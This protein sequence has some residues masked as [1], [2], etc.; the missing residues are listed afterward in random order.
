[1]LE[2][3]YKNACDVS[4][5]I[6]EHVPTHR[7]LAE[8]C[9]SVVEVG[10]RSMVSTWGLLRG[11][12]SGC[13]YTGID[14]CMPPEE[15][16]TKARFVC[17]EAGIQFNFICRD[18]ML[19][20][21]TEVG[22]CD[23]LF[24]DS[25]HTYCHLR[26]E[27]EKFSGLAKKYIT[28]HDTSAPWDTQ[29][30]MDYSG[31]YSEYPAHYDRTKRGTWAAIEHFLENNSEWKIRER[32][33]NN[34]GFTIL[35]RVKT[36]PIRGISFTIPFEKIVKEAPR[37][38]VRMESLMIPGKQ[39]TYI[40]EIEE[41]YYRQYQESHFAITMKKRGW[42]CLR[43]LEIMANGC[44]PVF[45]GF[46]E[47]PELTLS[48]YP[49]Q[50]QR[51]INEFYNIYRYSDIDEPEF[52]SLYYE[53]LERV[54]DYVRR[55]MTTI[56]AARR[57]LNE[58]GHANA[59][60]I[61]FLGRERGAD[62]LRCLTLHGFKSILGVN[63]HDFCR[64]PHLYKSYKETGNISKLY[65][66][67]FTYS[68]LIPDE[69]HANNLDNYF[70]IEELIKKHAFELIIF[71]SETRGLMLYNLIIEHYHPNDIVMLNGEDESLP[72]NKIQHRPYWS[73]VRELV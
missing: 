30:D 33:F 55:N 65:G 52:V 12:R 44:L 7:K 56:S 4:S 8:E 25:L 46:E 40:Y 60:K 18:D 26:Y 49:K 73:F 54:L 5:D 20:D 31:D 21:S 27:I 14:I 62:Y 19:I 3:L 69:Y 36:A 39:E 1:M 24:I 63:C 50:L 53:L 70:L 34:H 35:E 57:I 58:T 29:D 10:V 6:N 17:E 59:T 37:N 51:E 43:H 72:A 48:M 66:K 2:S 68:A 22:P 47:C 32:K 71:G 38:K 23:M 45:I 67:G 16:M 28:F 41:E 61:L 13:K 9:E 11:L 42:D 64:I 15:N